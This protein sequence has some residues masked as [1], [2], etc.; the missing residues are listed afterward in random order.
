MATTATRLTATV[1][2][3]TAAAS[4]A[5]ITLAVP[6]GVID[7]IRWRVPPGPRGHLG[8]CLAMGGV[9]VLPDDSGTFIVADNEYDELVVSGLPDSGAWQLRGYNTGS[10]DHTVYLDFYTTPTALASQPVTID[11]TGFPQ[12]EAD[13]PGMWL[14]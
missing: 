11:S 12:S 10:Y 14:T 5:T 4:P 2:A 13:I 1:P 7:K 3:G 9:Q 8:W 6:A